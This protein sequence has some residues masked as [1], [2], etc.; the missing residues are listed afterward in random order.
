M[1]KQS[2]EFAPDGEQYSLADL[3]NIMRHLSSENGCPWDR[4]QTHHSLERYLLEESW[5]AVEA[6]EQNDWQNLCG[7]RCP[8]A[9]CVSCGLGRAGGAL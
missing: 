7:G 6:I 3:V 1:D 5:E 4:R 2:F 8:D 9:N